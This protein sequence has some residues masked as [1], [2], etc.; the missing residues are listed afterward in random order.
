MREK[1]LTL[2]LAELRKIAKEQGLKAVSGYRKS[3]LVDKL[4]ELKRLRRRERSLCRRRKRLCREQRKL[5][6]EP[7]SLLSGRQRRN[8]DALSSA[9]RS[10]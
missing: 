1:L 5:C 8:G 3:E 10:G 4:C 7:R 2:P 9:D 6:R